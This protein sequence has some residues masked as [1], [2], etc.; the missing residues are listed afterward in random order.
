MD[1]GRVFGQDKALMT[2]ELKV[3]GGVGGQQMLLESQS[4]EAQGMR[5]EAGAW[6]DR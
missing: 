1:R 3:E 4:D 5:R 2:A 6:M